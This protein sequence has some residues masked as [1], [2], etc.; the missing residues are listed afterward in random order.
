M[1]KS[2]R[3]SQKPGT[4][5]YDPSRSIASCFLEFHVSGNKEKAFK[6][7]N[8]LIPYSRQRLTSATKDPLYAAPLS[9]SPGMEGALERFKRPSRP[10]ITWGMVWGPGPCRVFL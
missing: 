1:V 5:I 7:V 10:T 2:W 6:I 3:S 8:D 4:A 9:Q